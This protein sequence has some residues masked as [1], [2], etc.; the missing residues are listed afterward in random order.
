MFI[1]LV[2]CHFL[3]YL[4]LTLSWFLGSEVGGVLLQRPMQ[5]Q[6]KAKLHIDLVQYIQCKYC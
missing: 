4:V 6:A 2:C 3:F 1:F 5:I